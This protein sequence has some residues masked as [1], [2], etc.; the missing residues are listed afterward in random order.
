MT[1][2]EIHA[3][4][5]VQQ[6]MS[7]SRAAEQLYIS[8][9][10]LSS[11]LQTLEH[12]LGAPL[13]VRGRGR[14]ELTLSA[15]GERFLPLARQHRALEEKMLTVAHPEQPQRLL[16]ISTLSSIGTC[17][18]PP[19][20]DR[21]LHRW[22]QVR[23]EIRAH[24]TST[25]RQQLARDKLD[26]VFSTLNY[27][28]EQVTSIHVCNEPMAF[29]CSAD[30]D[31]PDPVPLSALSPGRQIYSFWC[32][33]LSAW[34]GT[35]LGPDFQSRARLELVSQLPLFLSLPNAWTIA[36]ES[37][38]RAFQTTPGLRRC[39]MDFQPPSRPLYLLCRRESLPTP[40]V[41]NFLD[42]LREVLTEEQFPDLLL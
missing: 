18:L 2:L 21:Y 27:H 35:A 36:P 34:L 40:S 42:T 9:S 14:R 24:S 17:L 7:I 32:S 10:S 31:Y 25:A 39:G 41:Q 6:N 5:A 38:V 23:L 26:L 28:N 20:F 12:E 22:P 13:F 30:S 1:S 33:D 37:V 4:L 8:Q 15:E 11:R 16:R 29:L 19:V 3:F